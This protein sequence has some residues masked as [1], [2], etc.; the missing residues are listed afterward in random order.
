MDVGRNLKIDAGKIIFFQHVQNVAG[1]A[2]G[3]VWFYY[4]AKR[5]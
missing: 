4:G 1:N 2:G 5:C 3:E